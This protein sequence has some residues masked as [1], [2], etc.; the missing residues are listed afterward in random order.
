MARAGSMNAIDSIASDVVMAN[1]EDLSISE[2]PSLAS[3]VPETARDEA[4]NVPHKQEIRLPEAASTPVRSAAGEELASE[5]E[6]TATA[7]ASALPAAPITLSTQSQGV[8]TEFDLAENLQSILEHLNDTDA[9]APSKKID[10]AN[11]HS[12]CFKIGL[13]AQELAMTQQ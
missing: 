6:H 11:I 9:S 2:L 3:E 12:L 4:P 8:D 1:V 7:P 13:R 10:L 5:I